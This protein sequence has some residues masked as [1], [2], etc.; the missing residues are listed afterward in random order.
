MDLPPTILFEKSGH[1]ATITINRPEAMNAVTGEMSAGIDAAFEAFNADDDLWVV[2]LTGAGP[3]PGSGQA[4]AFCSGFDLKEAIPRV[5]AGDML[6]YDDPTKRQFSDTFKPIIAAVN[7]LCV[8]G[9]LE[10]VVGTDLRIAAPTA[11]VNGVTPKEKVYAD[12][13][14]YASLKGIMAAKKKPIEEL[15]LASLGVDTN[16]RLK[17]KKLQARK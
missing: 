9:G 2:I 3:S 10:M 13:P 16:L 11:V 8:A 1:V 17:V 4:P 7:G 5:T 6:G 15:A 12:G 14:R